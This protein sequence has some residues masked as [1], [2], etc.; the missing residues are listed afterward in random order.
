MAYSRP[1]GQRS[2]LPITMRQ[3]LG[4]EKEA[5]STSH[6]PPEMIE[7]DH[8]RVISH[9][10]RSVQIMSPSVKSY[11]TGHGGVLSICPTFYL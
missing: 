1:S 2:H 6:R 9:V 11:L 5:S 4:D 3:K 7:Y 8:E 10:M